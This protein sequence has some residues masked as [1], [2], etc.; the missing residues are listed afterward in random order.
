M[1]SLAAYGENLKKLYPCPLVT[2]FVDAVVTAYTPLLN[3]NDTT[4]VCFAGIVSD[5]MTI[6]ASQIYDKLSVAA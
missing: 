2:K 6:I 4:T 5:R 3:R 1:G